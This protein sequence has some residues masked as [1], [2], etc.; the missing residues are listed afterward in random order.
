MVKKFVKKRM[1][2]LLAATL[3]L[4]GFN[5]TG[6]WDMEVEASNDTEKFHVEK[7]DISD[8]KDNNPVSKDSQYAD[9]MFAGWYKD[10]TCET[11]VT[12]K[13]EETGE[14]Y[15]KFVPKEVLSVLCQTQVNTNENTDT[16]KMRIVSTVD[17]LNY[18]E[19]GFRITVGNS[20]ITRSIK[21]VYKNIK[22]V[23]G[24]VPISYQ[25]NALSE[26]STYFS[27][28][29]ITNISNE[30]FG[31]G[32]LIEPY[33]KTV[34]GSIVYGVSRYARVED[35]Y[36]KIVNVPVRLYDRAGVAGGYAEIKYDTSKF[37]Y[38]G[39]DNGTVFDNLDTY[40]ENGVVKCVGDINDISKN[41]EAYGLYANLR[42]KVKDTDVNATFQ[43]MNT[44]FCNINE[45]IIATNISNVIN[46]VI[47][48]QLIVQSVPMTL[49]AAGNGDVNGDNKTSVID[50]IVA[51]KDG[52]NI[53][54]ADMN[55]DG[56]INGEDYHLI[57]KEILKAPQNELD[58][59]ME[60]LDIEISGTSVTVIMK[61]TSSVWEAES[62]TVSYTYGEGQTG[63]FELGTVKPGVTKT[64]QITV[65]ENVTEITV[66]SIIADYW[67][68]TVK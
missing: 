50:L 38:Y 1:S 7:L 30:S 53:E 47:P 33:W 35:G 41:A 44:E 3:I 45:E 49:S 23:E 6:V 61:N 28:L 34:D 10:M 14:Q 25:P 57:R 9:W 36:L 21:T 51:R 46:R 12:D 48:M 29:T 60:V 17:T 66:T 26:A 52:V 42:F 27:T 15:A 68:V 40:A 13:Q 5:M 4:S 31:S 39:S 24:G 59:V 54:K 56:N 8:Y 55:D 16:T 65:P 37:A 64:Y 2:I 22:A 20:T 62:G 11:Y 58:G 18:R 43:V 63:T 19:V 67:S 32:I